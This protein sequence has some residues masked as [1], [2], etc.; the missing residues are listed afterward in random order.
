VKSAKSNFF[1]MI[2][3]PSG[4]DKLQF[5][6]PLSLQNTSEEKQK[7][8]SAIL[9]QIVM[10][11]SD[12]SSN[13]EALQPLLAKC[14]ELGLTSVNV[15]IAEDMGNDELMKLQRGVIK[16]FRDV[17]L[18]IS[19]PEGANAS[20]ASFDAK[21]DSGKQAEDSGDSSSDDDSEEAPPAAKTKDAVEEKMAE[22]SDSDSSSDDEEEEPKQA[23]VEAVKSKEDSDDSDSSSDEEEEVAA[24]QPPAKEDSSDS[25]SSSDD[26]EEEEA[27]KPAA[28]AMQVEENSDS[29][30]DSSSDEEE[31]PK[32]VEK[33]EVEEDSD[34]DSS[35]D[36]EEETKAEKKEAAES[37]SDDSSDGSDDEEETKAAPAAKKPADDG[38]SSSS[39]SD[40]D[41]EEEKPKPVE[42]A[43]SKPPKKKNQPFRRVR[44]SGQHLES[45]AWDASKHG[46]HGAEAF[47][48][49][50]RHQGKE[51]IKAKNKRK[52]SNRSGYGSIDFAVR[53]TDLT[54]RRK[55]G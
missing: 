55:L 38:S 25:D 45:N 14:S 50:G 46:G 42:K 23:K 36:E 32:K 49:L 16:A 1:R 51:F 35:S 20:A 24:K 10:V 2:V 21:V 26:D 7:K 22:D 40:S 28:T 47:E 9:A 33:M 41:E 3:L 53:S 29:D 39:D 52:R 34:S 13:A 8:W 12:K 18:S 48:K 37:S 11:L 54:K 15:A 19:K 27:K 30:S 43:P 17:G 31:A 4:I 5:T 44:A 6:L